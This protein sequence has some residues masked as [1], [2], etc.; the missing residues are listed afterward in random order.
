MKKTTQSVFGLSSIRPANLLHTAT[1][2]QTL[3]IWQRAAKPCAS[4]QPM[5][6]LNL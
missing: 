6:P 4:T 3:K 1:N 5:K 2:R